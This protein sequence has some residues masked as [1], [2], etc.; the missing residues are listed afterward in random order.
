MKIFVKIVLS[1]SMVLYLLIL[2]KLILFKTF[3][4]TEMNGHISFSHG[5]YWG[6]HN[7]IP[8]KTIAHYL[9]L[10]DVNPSIRIE[11][12]AGNIIGFVP[13]GLMLPLLSKRFS[14]LKSILIATFCLSFT[15]EILQLLF[16]LGSFDTDDLILNTLGGV[17][18]YLPIKLFYIVFK[19]NGTIRSQAKGQ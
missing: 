8:F 4:I 10:A 16:E 2:T 14:Q 7:F 6:S 17:I 12:I 13:F 3:S 15:Y 11:N 1:L 5:R 18:G 19:K 9:F